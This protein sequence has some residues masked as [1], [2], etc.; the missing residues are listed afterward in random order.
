M[1]QVRSLGFSTDLM[2]LRAG[3]S[4]VVDMGDHAVART[5]GEPDYWWG[6]FVLV[7]AG[8]RVGEGLDAFRRAFPTARHIA[9]GVDG[10]DGE[11]PPAAGAL[12]LA[13][14]VGVVLTARSLV[15]APPVDAEVRVLSSAADWRGLVELRRQD[16]HPGADASFEERR[17]ATARRLSE[18]KRGYFLGAWRG[19]MLVSALGIVSNGA[20]TARFQDAQTHPAHRRQGLASHLVVA[21]AS[22][23]SRRWP[24][25][26]LVV[27]ADP[28]GPALGVYE[29]LGFEQAEHQVQLVGASA[30]RG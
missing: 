21:A 23:A 16:G 29:A 22:M 27:V 8:G 11:A 7:G 14:D 24:L 17:V 20:G 1:M 4:S 26:R 9:I 10:T 25:E 5:P 28:S 2:V 3:G 13:L 18:S 6:N 12:G 30:T 19:G 15:P